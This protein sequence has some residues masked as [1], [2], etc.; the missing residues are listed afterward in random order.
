MKPLKTVQAFIIGR[1]GG[2]S[3]R[4]LAAELKINKSTAAD[5]DKK[6]RKD[7]NIMQAEALED[8]YETYGLARIERLKALGGVKQQLENALRASDLSK[9]PPDR[10]LELYIKVMAFVSKEY[11]ATNLSEQDAPIS[12]Q[13]FIEAFNNIHNASLQGESIERTHVNTLT[14]KHAL[15]AYHELETQK[16]IDEIQEA[17]EQQ[18]EQQSRRLK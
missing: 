9:I 1:A 5:W 10:L 2:K 13:S 3:L 7:I 11:V 12:P 17:L 15:G 8:V 14:T 16:K 6:Y 18:A 4:T